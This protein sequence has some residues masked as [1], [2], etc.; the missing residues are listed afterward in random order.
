MHQ[1]LVFAAK[2]PDEDELRRNIEGHLASVTSDWMSDA[3]M[4]ERRNK[5]ELEMGRYAKIPEWVVGATVRIREKRE[6]R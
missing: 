1:E 3:A 4:R 5:G 6:S 2:I